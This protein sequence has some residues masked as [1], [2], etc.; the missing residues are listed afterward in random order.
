[1][2]IS[3]YESLFNIIEDFDE[4]IFKKIS[5]KTALIKLVDYSLLEQLENQYPTIMHLSVM[6][7]AHRWNLYRKALRMDIPEENMHD[8]DE[9]NDVKGDA[10][11]YLN[12]S[13]EYSV[14]ILFSIVEMLQDRK[15]ELIEKAKEGEAGYI[16][17]E[18]FIRLNAINVILNDQKND[19]NYFENCYNTVRKFL[20]STHEKFL[21]KK[22]D[23][24]KGVLEEIKSK[25][26]TI[27]FLL[28]IFVGEDFNNYMGKWKILDNE[29]KMEDINM[30]IDQ[31]SQNPDKMDPN[32]LDE[33]VTKWNEIEN[34][35]YSGKTSQNF[36]K[37]LIDMHWVTINKLLIEEDS[38]LLLNLSK[39]LEFLI[40]A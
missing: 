23:Q 4:S 35:E 2:N 40:I 39:S 11:S 3:H 38:K 14:F 30:L 36:K 24:D 12:Y 34:K 29:C 20:S 16:I 25:R 31:F 5:T 28:T 37:W 19:L 26:G 13:S 18:I 1:M 22:F 32:E 27:Y 21:D 8:I 15:A 10:Y 6:D 7:P 17:K 33:F 9:E